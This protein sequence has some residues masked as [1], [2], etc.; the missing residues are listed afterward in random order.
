MVRSVSIALDRRARVRSRERVAQVSWAPRRDGFGLKC[1]RSR[2]GVLGAARHQSPR[3]WTASDPTCGVRAGTP[4]AMIRPSVSIPSRRRCRT[5]SGSAPPV[6]LHPRQRHRR[7]RTRPRSVPVGAAAGS[8]PTRSARC[9]TP[10]SSVPATRPPPPCRGMM[11]LGSCVYQPV[12]DVSPTPS[13]FQRGHH[14]RVHAHTVMPP[15]RPRPG[16]LERADHAGSGLPDGADEVV[17][18]LSTRSHRVGR[19]PVGGEPHLGE[20]HSLLCAKDSPARRP[21]T[22]SRPRPFPHLVPNW[23]EVVTPFC[24]MVIEEEPQ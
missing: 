23:S 6:R 20:Q 5:P 24:P 9:R 16:H 15:T 19:P 8:C 21:A 3:A 12:S 4:A 11:T 18:S 1:P 7:T 2:S 17:A 10:C 14:Q 13:P 22:P